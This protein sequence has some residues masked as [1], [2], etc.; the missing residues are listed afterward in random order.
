MKPWMVFTGLAILLVAAGVWLL[1]PQ[2]EV[3]T[4][5]GAGEEVVPE[6][7]EP[8]PIAVP[9]REAIPQPSEPE[10]ALDQAEVLRALEEVAKNQEALE[11]WDKQLAQACKLLFKNKQFEEAQ[12]CFN[13]R[14]ARNPDDG[15][16]YLDRGIL[17]A[18]MGKHIEAYWDYVKHL[19]LEPDGIRAPQV[20][21]IVAQYEEWASGT[22]AP[23]REDS[24]YRQEIADLAKML[25]EEAYVIKASSPETALKKLNQALRLLRLVPKEYQAYLGKIERLIER[26][27]SSQ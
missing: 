27:E 23:E 25:Y 10:P 1:W 6:E 2:A 21:K 15:K 20:R 7:P 16:A 18:R 8:P 12:Y 14:L 3:E 4:P 9:V 11:D 22:K 19:E 17:H 13:L 24:D 26:I 5:T